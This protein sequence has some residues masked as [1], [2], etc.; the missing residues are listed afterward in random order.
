MEEWL[1]NP[2]AIFFITGFF[3]LVQNRDIKKKINSNII[4]LYIIFSLICI[5]SVGSFWKN[6]FV[7]LIL[8]FIEIEILSTTEARDTL[9]VSARYKLIDFIFTTVNKYKIISMWIIIFLFN[10]SNLFSEGYI[11]YWVIYVLMIA[12]IFLWNIGRIYKNEFEVKNLDEIEK[13]YL[14]AMQGYRN[15]KRN[16]KLKEKLDLLLEVE[17][18]TFEHRRSSHT[19][20]CW[21]SLV[22]KLNKDYGT[23]DRINEINSMKFPYKLLY[24]LYSV[25]K[26]V[27]LGYKVFVVLVKGI[28][29]KQGLKRYLNRGYST[30]EM[31][32]IRTYGVVAGYKKTYIRKIYE[33]LYANIFFKSYARKSDH[34]N[35]LE[36]PDEI[37]YR[38]PYAYLNSVR[39][40]INGRVFRN[41]KG[42][43]KT[44]RD[45]QKLSKEEV[46]NIIYD[47]SIEEIFIFILG[48]SKKKI[49][50]GIFER[51]ADYIEKYN[52]NE[53]KLKKVIKKFN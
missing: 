45:K 49:N 19:I 16:E 48:L 5:F 20:L 28:F 11:A 15:P 51:Y 13:D 34:Y 22:Y 23:V 14:N 43:Y 39:T 41:I 10:M 47:L 36:K 17:D 52:M 46:N 25:K 21:E 31:Q 18:R 9:V 1:K 4:V 29:S 8:M 26:I 2:Y 37:K 7:V 32:L 24:A 50:N 53:N 3:M 35:Y 30:I 6:S 40:F 12:A 38:I 44:I 42:Y 33:L 27:K